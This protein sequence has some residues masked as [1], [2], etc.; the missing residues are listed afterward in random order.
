MKL[1]DRDILQAVVRDITEQKKSED[2][3]KKKINELERYKNATVGRELRIIELKKKIK[4]L[5]EKLKAKGK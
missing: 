5:E 3:L 2:E 4:K 1:K